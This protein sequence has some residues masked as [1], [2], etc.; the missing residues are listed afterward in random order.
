MKRQVALA[1]LLS[2]CSEGPQ[3]EPGAENEPSLEAAP[4]TAYLGH[5]IEL[6]IRGDG[7]HFLDGPMVVSA[8]GFD[9]GSVVAASDTALVVELTA[10]D[11]APGPADVLVSGPDGDFRVEGAVTVEPS[12]VVQSITG[13]AA[14]PT[15]L[16]VDLTFP[17]ERFPLVGDEP[18]TIEL[19][20]AIGVQADVLSVWVY[21]ARLRVFADAMADLDAASMRIEA[22]SISGPIEH[23]SATA[24][25]LAPRRP[26]AIDIAAPPAGVGAPGPYASALYRIEPLAIPSEV[27]LDLVVHATEGQPDPFLA[28][29]PA[30]GAWSDMLGFGSSVTFLSVDEPFW[31]LVVDRGTPGNY[32]YDL[33]ATAT[34]V[35]AFE[36]EP[37]DACGNGEP[38][39][40]FPMTIA[41]TLESDAAEDWFRVEIAPENAGMRLRARTS[42]GDA[43]TD[44]ELAISLACGDFIAGPIDND[45]HENLLSPPLATGSYDVRVRP[46]PTFPFDG[47]AY[48]I[49]LSLEP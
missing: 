47:S 27:K 6:Q 35:A 16:L 46:S 4:V 42:A 31:L 49:T 14:A 33:V 18:L 26:T 34:G 44:V 25:D 11:A 39:T 7:T 2:A 45:L 37:N 23:R 17:D 12:I 3:G 29:L 5:P 22:T 20:G 24:W 30:S 1:L 38:T 21:G 48:Q 32:S 36:S 13:L 41:A 28:L 8:E 40:A 10:I 15:Q 9:V 19:D 43:C